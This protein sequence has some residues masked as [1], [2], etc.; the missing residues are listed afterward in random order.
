MPNA[1]SIYV[2]K[3]SADE[4][5]VRGLRPES[6]LKIKNFLIRRNEHAARAYARFP[7]DIDLEVILGKPNANRSAKHSSEKEASFSMLQESTLIHDGLGDH[8]GNFADYLSGKIP[9]MTPT[10]GVN[11]H[12]LIFSQQAVSCQ[13]IE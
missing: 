9:I 1:Q 3:S 12:E 10:G 7:S 13:M 4:E 8:F 6:Q 2:K 11:S 5:V